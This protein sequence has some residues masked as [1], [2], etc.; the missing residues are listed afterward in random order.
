MKN[1]QEELQHLRHV[2]QRRYARAQ[3]LRHLRGVLR[4]L[5]LDHRECPER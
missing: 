2:N 1:R 5:H 3:P 4:E